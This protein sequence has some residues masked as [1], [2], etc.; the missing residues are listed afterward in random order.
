MFSPRYDYSNGL[1][2]PIGL[3]RTAA[4]KKVVERN[5]RSRRAF[6]GVG[7]DDFGSGPGRSLYTPDRTRA[8]EPTLVEDYLPNDLQTQNK[9]FKKII[10][11]D[12]VA[13]PATEY[14]KDMAFSQKVLVGGIDDPKVQQFYEDALESCGTVPIMPEL[15]NDFLIFGRCVLRLIPDKRKGYWVGSSSPDPDTV[16]II[17]SPFPNEPPLIDWQ[18]LSD[19]RDFA[20]MDD[21]RAREQCSR[22]DPV[23]LKMIRDGGVIPLEPDNTLF[24]PRKVFAADALGTSYLTRIIPFWVYE[25]ALID[26]SVAGA[27]RRAGPV[28]IA[29][30]PI[31]YSGEEIQD[32][33][34]QMFAAEEDPIGGK[35]V[36]REGVTVNP[37]G[38]GSADYWKISDEFDFLVQAKMRALG[39]SDTFLSGEANYNSM[40]KVL[41]VFLRKLQSVR[42]QFTD[43]ILMQKI[44]RN[45]ALQHNM[46]KR[47]EAELRHGIRY[48]AASRRLRHGPAWQQWRWARKR[49]PSDADLMLPKLTWDKPLEPTADRDYWDFLEQLAEKGFVIPMRKWAQAAGYDF[50]DSFEN[51]EG[52]IQDRVEMAK[53]RSAV[54]E[55]DLGT[56]EGGFGGGGLGG[57]LGGGGGG[58]DLGPGGGEEFGGPEPEAPSIEEGPAAPEL[59]PPGGGGEEGAGAALQAPRFQVTQPTEQYRSGAA[60]A[61]EGPQHRNLEA[62]LGRLPVWDSTDRVFGLPRRVVANLVDK[63]SHMELRDRVPAALYRRLR[64]RGLNTL[65]ADV[66]QYCA[67]RMGYVNKPDINSESLDAMQRWMVDRAEEKGL[68]QPVVNEM[69]L[70]SLL[71]PKRS[72][73]VGVAAIKSRDD[74]PHDQI[75]TGVA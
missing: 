6:F 3:S 9:I 51:Q 44:C 67:A 64:K 46:V 74:L 1:L 40:E 58:L 73:R 22:Q 45:L 19:V 12:T 17:P 30:V 71:K 49:A 24:L 2:R 54:E 60:A 27:R 23:L 72:S 28:W 59:P 26:A 69:D 37:L 29:N 34:D 57:D 32:I 31:D 63:V 16:R 36:F 5:R 8:E 53:Y 25:K 15:L 14:W 66:V 47:T 7:G 35:L 62:V 42:D 68:T 33:M 11:Y 56:E 39:I 75:L 55:I 10:A 48:D 65:Q 70:L 61:S 4:M 50:S 13:G 41:T 18:P 52:D 38:G 43:A 21:D 20:M